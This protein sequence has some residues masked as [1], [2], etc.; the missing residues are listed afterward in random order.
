MAA[1][2]TIETETGPQPVAA[3]LVMHGLGADGN[4]FVPIARELDLAEVGPVRFVFP[5]APVIPVTINNGYRMRAWYDI[6]GLGGG[7]REDEA[8]L[9]RSMAEIEDLLQREK[10]RGMP[11]D[12]IVLA[13][14]S[15]GCAMA[16]MTGVRHKARL[17]GI[18]GMSGYLPLARTTAAERSDAN[19]PT[20]IFMGHGQ[21]DDVVDI[22]RGEAS[23]DALR[24]WG[25]EVEWH[26]YPMPH[27][28]CMEEIAD[29]GRWLVKVLARP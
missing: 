7:S 25:Y 14:F 19:A 26:D 11:A 20:P 23:R 27:S 22:A 18:A 4:D 3:I 9:R 10:E 6:L 13:G 17:A 2:E 1:L 8:G 5:H 16:L 24:A 21:H 28:V 29:L 12:R 15:Q